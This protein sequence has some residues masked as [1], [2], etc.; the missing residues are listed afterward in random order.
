MGSP[1]EPKVDEVSGRKLALIF[2]LIGKGELNIT[3]LIDHSVGVRYPYIEKVMELKPEEVRELLESLTAEKLLKKSLYD[4]VFACPKCASINLSPRG[5]C[6]YC[7]SFDIEKK[8]LLEHLRDGTKFVVNKLFEGVKP[9]CPRDGMELEP[10]EYRVLA[11]WFEC[12]ICKRKF[13]TPEV[14]FHCITCGLDFKARE[15]EFL[16][17][18]SYSLSEEMSDYVEKLANLKI[19]AESFTSAG[20]NVRFIENLEGLSGSMHKFDIVAYKIEKEKEIK[21][22][23]DLYKGE[24]EVDGSVVISMFAKVL[25]VKPDK[26][27]CVAIPSLSGVGKNLAKQYNIEVVEGSNAEEAA[28]TL[29]K[30]VR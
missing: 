23:L 14:G 11:S 9:V 27:V 8:R 2:K 10:H 17:V 19:L 24:G 12:N 20:Y 5:L 22:V 1:T 21:V 16:E 4:K 28:S 6:P 25:D 13:D 15:G 29:S 18:Y 30:L 7:G 3:P 26:A